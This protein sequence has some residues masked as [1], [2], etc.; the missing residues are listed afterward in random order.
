[1]S[2][3]LS[4]SDMLQ[5]K[6]IFRLE[7]LRQEEV[8]REIGISQE[9]LCRILNGK[10]RGRSGAAQK[11]FDKYAHKLRVTTTVSQCR[12][13]IVAAALELWDGE[14]ATAEP[15]VAF[16]RTAKILSKA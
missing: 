7:G 16:L 9:Q 8:A 14:I 5:L 12:D 13:D 15:L 11:L 2:T 1:M 10:V 6:E 4:S 3:T